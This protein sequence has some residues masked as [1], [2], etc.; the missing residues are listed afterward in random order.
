MELKIL[1]ASLKK[2]KSTLNSPHST[3][4]NVSLRHAKAHGGVVTAADAGGGANGVAVTAPIVAHGEDYRS[5][6]DLI[7]TQNSP[8]PKKRELFTHMFFSVF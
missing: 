2:N 8:P 5:V 7:P 4:K 6:C 1:E 3:L